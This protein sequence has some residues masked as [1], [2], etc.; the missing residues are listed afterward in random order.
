MGTYES[1]IPLYMKEDEKFTKVYKYIEDV[2][3]QIKDTCEQMKDSLKFDI[4][5]PEFLKFI[6]IFGQAPVYRG[7]GREVVGLEYKS[8]TTEWVI[9]MTGTTNLDIVLPKLAL[10]FSAK[11]N[12]LKNNFNGS[13][14]NLKE[15]MT[16]VFE[17]EKTYIGVDCKQNIV[18]DDENIEHPA[19][20]IIVNLYA[21]LEKRF[22][23]IEAYLEGEDPWDIRNIDMSWVTDPDHPENLEKYMFYKSCLEL[24]TLFQNGYFKLDILGVLTVFEISENAPVLRWG[25]S[26]WNE[27]TWSN[28]QITEEE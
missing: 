14:K 15:S 24:L 21:E 1:M 7:E 23:P 9:T 19:V 28:T 12:S 5:S 20:I 4:N 16:K 11:F 2:F 8:N 10:Y 26:R 25:H 3:N 17:V 13:F 6:S 18:E 22:P 27:A